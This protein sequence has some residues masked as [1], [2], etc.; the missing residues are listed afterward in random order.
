MDETLHMAMDYDLWWRLYKTFGPLEFVDSFLATNREHQE[1]KTSTRRKE[2]YREAMA[3]V[4][5]HYGRIP[6]K[7]WLAPPYSVWY[8]SMTNN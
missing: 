3:V 2:H 4:H 8:R 5:R 1:T 7:W 6:L